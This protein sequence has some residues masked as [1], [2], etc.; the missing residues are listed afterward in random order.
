MHVLYLVVCRHYGCHTVASGVCECDAG[1][2]VYRYVVLQIA[3][4]HVIKFAIALP[5]MISA[6]RLFISERAL[7]R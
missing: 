2:S 6:A 7:F 4:V 3:I 1:S 5:L